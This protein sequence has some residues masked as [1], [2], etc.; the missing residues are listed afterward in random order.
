M[1]S[2]TSGAHVHIICILPFS[3]CM[4][5]PFAPHAC[6]KHMQ[7]LEQPEERVPG[8]KT[9]S[10]VAMEKLAVKYCTKRGGGPRTSVQIEAEMMAHIAAAE[11][12][13]NILE[14]QLNQVLCTCYTHVS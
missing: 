13:S 4:C 14:R 9:A 6:S 8:G 12:K 7:V 2:F 5:C 1:S 11:K 10:R 3:D